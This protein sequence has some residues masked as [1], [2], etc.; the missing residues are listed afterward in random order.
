MAEVTKGQ[1][2]VGLGE[3]RIAPPLLQAYL[4]TRYRAGD[5]LLQVGQEN[6]PLRTTHGL[7]GVASSVFITAWNPYSQTLAEEDNRKAQEELRRVV[8]DHSWES[9]EGYGQH[10]SNGW[11]VEP[12]LL[13]FGPDLEE[14]RLLGRQFGQ[15]AVVWTGESAVPRLVLLE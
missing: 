11:P 4:E 8:R 14:A 3:S 2:V 7:Y 9:L 5:L 1:W 12:S 15:N 10:P 6:E 13:V